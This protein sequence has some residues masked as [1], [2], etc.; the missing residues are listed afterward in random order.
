MVACPW[1]TKK[2]PLIGAG[3]VVRALRM[4]ASAEYHSVER[5]LILEGV[6]MRVI[7]DGPHPWNP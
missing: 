5:M 6:P 7:K 4:A 2:P 3:L 1:K